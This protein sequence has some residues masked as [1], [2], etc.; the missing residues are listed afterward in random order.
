MNQNLLNIIGCIIQARM[1]ST[2]LPGKVMLSV[3]DSNTVIWYVTNQMK[4]SKFC[5]K[6]IVATTSL[7]EDDRIVDFAKKNPFNTL[8]VVSRIV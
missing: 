3:D 8:E 4:H 6:L 5:E 1:G 7:A 2:R